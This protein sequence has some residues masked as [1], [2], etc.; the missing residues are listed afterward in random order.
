MLGQSI[1]QPLGDAIGIGIKEAHPRD[2]FHLSKPREQFGES[3]AQA[4]IFAIG[5]SV[6]PDQ[7]DLA[8]P[9][10]RKVPRLAHHGLEPSAAEIS[11]KLRNDAKRTGMIAP[12]CNLNVGGVARRGKHAG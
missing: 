8:D 7:R 6:L 9:R 5:S 1:E 12:F 11:P 2:A 3:V 4:K 10:L